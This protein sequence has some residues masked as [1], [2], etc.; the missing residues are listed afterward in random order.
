MKN[1]TARMLVECALMV[2]VATVLSLIKIDLPFGGGLTI[3]S[4]LPIILISHRYDLKTGILTAEAYSL[5][6]LFLGMDNLAYATT[7]LT[8]L[9][10]VFLDYVVA[11]SVLGFSGV[12]DK[13]M[14]NKRA[15]LATGIA[16]TFVLRF[17][18]HLIS[19]AWIWG[20]WMPEEFMG[21][22]MTNPWLYS[23][24]YNGWYMLAELILTEIVALALYAP[25]GKYFR[26]EDLKRQ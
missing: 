15:A 3:C 26:G 10:V 2:A 1:K 4:M 18:C 5:I 23:A 25:L 13:L 19:G 24:L 20:V 6:Q 14:K 8:I 12:F 21:M 7:P 11:Y 9:G 22:T 17:V 16:V